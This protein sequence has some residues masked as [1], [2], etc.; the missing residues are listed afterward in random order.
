MQPVSYGEIFIRFSV[1]GLTAFGGPAAHVGYFR[2]QFVQRRRWLSEA[3]FAA[4][5]AL[6]QFLPGPASSQVGF[7]I[8]YRLRGLGGGVA[9]FAG[10]TLPAFGLMLALAVGST[11]LLATSWFDGVAAGL[12]LLA[13]AVVAQAVV[14]MFASFCNNHPTR[15]LCAASAVVLIVL[16]GIA[17]QIGLLLA[18]AAVG[19]AWFTPQTLPQVNDAAGRLRFGP[20]LVFVALLIGLP[21]LAGHSVWLELAND[22][23]QAGSWVFGGGHVVLPLLQ[24]LVGDALSA[25][26]FLTGYA[27]AQ[28]VPGPMFSLAAYL[29]ASVLPHNALAAASPALLAIFLPGFLLLVA[30]QGSWAR[31]CAQPRLN[32]AVQGVNA[33][34]VGLLLAALWQPVAV[35]AI[36]SVVDATAALLGFALLRF[37]KW[38]VLAVVAAFVVYGLLG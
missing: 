24:G 10:F 38:P 32:G 6:C 7:A 31:L 37:A 36:H 14:G 3:D 20:L 16:P 19:A 22:F 35:S 13:V 30:V 26:E 15:I 34:V 2:E 11:K 8:G 33:A 25:D 17:V 12:K 4:L 1:L 27:A 28:A 5:L 9:A 29:G 23:Y 21:L 18:A